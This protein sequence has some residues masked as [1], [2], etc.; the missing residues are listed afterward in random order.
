[1]T[2]GSIRNKSK[3]IRDVSLNRI[4]TS[5]DDTLCIIESLEKN[6]KF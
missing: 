1:M 5:L 6:L 3:K 4:R 2:S